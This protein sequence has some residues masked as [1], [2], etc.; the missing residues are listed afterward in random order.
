MPYSNLT[1]SMTAVE[2][3]ARKT[4][5]NTAKTSLTP[6][7]INLTMAERTGL[8]K[9]GPNRYQLGQI[10]INIGTNN[11]N[12]LTAFVSLNDAKD[13]FLSYQQLM[14][15]KQILTEITE[16]VDDAMMARGSEVMSKYVKP[17]YNN[18]KS[19]REQNVPG[20]DSAFD[21]MNPFYDLPDQ[22]DGGEPEV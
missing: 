21:A 8:Y 18:I 20:A 7:S 4:E 9:M 2:L 6:W 17:L 19:A 1:G 16:G 10:A 12:L 14:E 15:L 11:A 3:A 5:L 22:P 13:D